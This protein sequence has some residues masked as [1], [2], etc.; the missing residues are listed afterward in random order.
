MYCGN[1]EQ[2]A[3]IV[4]R[5]FRRLRQQQI[6]ESPISLLFTVITAV[7]PLMEIKKS[8]QGKDTRHITFPLTRDRRFRMAIL[9][10]CR[11]LEER[12][13][14]SF[15]LRC[16]AELQA[17]IAD[18]RDSWALSRRSQFEKLMVENDVFLHFRWH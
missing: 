17:I 3:N 16:L 2:I 4:Y 11:A 10:F 8:R 12:F 1:R 5:L 15:E 9:W 14:P 6:V 7:Q 13:E 18:S